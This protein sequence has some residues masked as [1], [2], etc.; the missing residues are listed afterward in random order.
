MSWTVKNLAAPRLRERVVDVHMPGALLA[1][2]C[3][4]LL[5]TPITMQA[6]PTQED[7]AGLAPGN[8]ALLLEDGADDDPIVVTGRRE[9]P[10]RSQVYEQ[11]R[12]LSRVDHHRLYEEP[13]ARF[14]TP[15][16]PAVSGLSTAEAR[17]MIARIRANAARVDVKLARPDCM[18]NLVVVFADDGRTLMVKVAETHRKTFCTLPVSEQAELLVEGA[19]VRVWSQI[20]VVG[21]NA[22][23]WRCR[24]NVPSR[25]GGPGQ[26]L[27]PSRREIG[28]ALVVF[29]RDAVVSMTLMQLADYAT[30]RGLSHTRPAR[31]HEPMP[32]ILA[33]FT[34]GASIPEELTHFDIGYLRSLYW[35]VPNVPAASKLRGVRR[36]ALRE[37]DPLAISRK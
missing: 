16:C 32:T 13:L 11:A 12:E 31:G 8:S 21:P 23:V 37:E 25:S 30:M 4:V 3:A 14:E 2:A 22:H 24:W 20:I 28:S 10:T 1:A 34:E 19:P 29:D 15:L 7:N 5:A 36:R 33:L 27:L 35:W 18:P 26:M 6:T 9:P 17:L